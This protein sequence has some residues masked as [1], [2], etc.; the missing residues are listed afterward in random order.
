MSL[1][2]SVLSRHDESSHFYNETFELWHQVWSGF[3]SKAENREEFY[4]DPFLFNDEKC[5]ISYENKPIAI[6][7]MSYFKKNAKSR[8]F[9]SY[10]LQYPEGIVNKAIESD[11]VKEV[12]L[13][14]NIT[15]HPNF[16]KS[17]PAL[18]CAISELQF[19][20]AIKRYQNIGSDVLLGYCR[21]EKQINRMAYE[22]GAEVLASGV[23]HGCETDF[24]AIYKPNIKFNVDS[25]VISV[26][27]QL[28]EDWMQTEFSSVA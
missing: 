7:L 13:Y 19:T 26:A 10:L 20:L 5:V 9:S 3:Y 24:I 2:F 8:L 27:S 22:H 11:F 16:R 12:C 17:N 14:S 6:W 23:R 28:Y 1:R 4:S 15:V 25:K 18:P 21:N